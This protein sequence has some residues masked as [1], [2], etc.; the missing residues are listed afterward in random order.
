MNLKVREYKTDEVI[1]FAKT[2]GKFGGLSN[3]APGYSLFVNE[4]NIQSSE[5]LYQ[6]FRFSLFPL[7]QEEIFRA[8]N[9]MDAKKIS[10]KYNNYSR[11]DWDQVKFKIMKWTLEV[12][13]IQNYKKFSEL[14][15]STGNLPIVEYS[16][17]DNIWGA[18]PANENTLIGV[19]AL[20][21]LL[22]ELREKILTGQIHADSVIY[23]LDIPAFLL[24]NKPVGEVYNDSYFIEDLDDIYAY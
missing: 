3:M 7:I 16:V 21:R 19:N 20:G 24:F 14:L 11:Q 4:V 15:L 9:P 1:T 17:K 23:P 5:L 13:L 10:R 6:A 2:S 12:K 8:E 18:M 22:M